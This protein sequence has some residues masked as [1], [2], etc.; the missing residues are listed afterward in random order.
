MLS[1]SQQVAETA[2]HTK[3]SGLP[4]APETCND[5]RS[6]S[7]IREGGEAVALPHS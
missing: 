2:V 3:D 1:F 6:A 5:N 4:R 7:A